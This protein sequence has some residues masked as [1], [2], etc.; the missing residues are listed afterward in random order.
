[1]FCVIGRFLEIS[2]DML[3][4]L[5]IPEVECLVIVDYA[6][7]MHDIGLVCE[8]V[9]DPVFKDP[10]KILVFMSVVVGD[11]LIPLKSQAGL[12][13]QDGD[14][15]IIP[16][17]DAPCQDQEPEV[18]FERGKFFRGFFRKLCDISSRR[19]DLP[20]CYCGQKQGDLVDCRIDRVHQREHDRLDV[21]A[22]M[23][24][25]HVFRVSRQRDQRTAS[26]AFVNII[27]V[28]LFMYFYFYDL[29][30][31]LPPAFPYK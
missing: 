15:C 19:A 24:L 26:R 29:S 28:F 14:D 31:I 8:I 18:S 11:S 6:V 3:A 22:V 13:C 21:G 16:I 27:N 20:V 7:V 23:A 30:R 4:A 2:L 17:K 9:E 25:S 1:M 10:C 5:E 12:F